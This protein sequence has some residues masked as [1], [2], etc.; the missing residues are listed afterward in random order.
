VQI[1]ET[2][3]KEIFIRG[4]TVLEINC[5]EG[6]WSREIHWR[7]AKKI[8]CVNPLPEAKQYTDILKDGVTY[9]ENIPNNQTY[10]IVFINEV[11]AEQ[12]VDWLTK[13]K[14]NN[15]LKHNKTSIIVL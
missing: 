13:I 12:A 8:H 11:K 5:R 14:E 15:L 6:R 2:I 3:D 7:Y 10:D 1:F 4:S 9:S